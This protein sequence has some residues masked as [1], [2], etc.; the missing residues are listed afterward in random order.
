MDGHTDVG[1]G[2]DGEDV[3][4]QE[5]D[6]RFE[7]VHEEQQE[8]PD[9]RR[10]AGDEIH[11]EDSGLQEDGGRQREDGEN[12]MTGEHVAVKSDSQR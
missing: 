6:E 11:L 7:G 8:E 1:R 9:E 12:H 10:D 2:E 3:C 4:L 5:R